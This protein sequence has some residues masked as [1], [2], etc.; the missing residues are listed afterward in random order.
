MQQYKPAILYFKQHIRPRHRG[1]NERNWIKMVK[2]WIKLEEN[3]L[4]IDENWKKLGWQVKKIREIG[5]K[6]KENP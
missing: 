1:G 3:R 2:K 6:W 4:K 5:L